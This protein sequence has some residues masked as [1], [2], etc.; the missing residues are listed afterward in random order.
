MRPGRLLGDSWAPLGPPWST[1]W[2]LLGASW[3]VLFFFPRVLGP[4]WG[5][6]GVVRPPLGP[7]RSLSGRPGGS[8]LAP[9]GRENESKQRNEKY[10][11]YH[12]KTNDFEGQRGPLGAPWGALGQLFWNAGAPFRHDRVSVDVFAQPFPSQAPLGPL[13]SPPWR[14]KAEKKKNRNPLGRV[15][16]ASWAHLG[17]QGRVRPGLAWNGKSDNGLK[18][19]S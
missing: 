13:F 15:L 12:C 6:P 17:S 4:T 9:R 11:F 7:L 3:T 2:R 18:S 19:W 16:G 5:P 8:F 14:P 10:T 1:S